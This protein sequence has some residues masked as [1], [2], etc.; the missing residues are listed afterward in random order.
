MIAVREPL[1]LGETILQEW[2]FFGILITQKFSA[3]IYTKPKKVYAIVYD[4]C[5]TVF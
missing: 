5:I 1:L 3:K 2:H 4:S